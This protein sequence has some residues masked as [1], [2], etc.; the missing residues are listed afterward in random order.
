MESEVTRVNL[1]AIVL[2]ILGAARSMAQE[3]QHG[4]AEKL[5]AVHFAILCNEVAQKEFNRAVALLHTFQFSRAI[6]GFNA[7]LVQDATCGIA[8]WDLA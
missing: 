2:L 3:H 4:T 1:V 5:G 8:Y 7:V 6:E